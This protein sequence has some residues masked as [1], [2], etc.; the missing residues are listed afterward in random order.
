MYSGPQAH[1]IAAYHDNRSPE[2]IA[3]IYLGPD[4]VPWAIINNKQVSNPVSILC[5]T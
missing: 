4:T 3:R 2:F 5:S 1:N